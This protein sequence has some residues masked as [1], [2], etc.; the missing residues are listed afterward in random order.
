MFVNLFERMFDG[1][2]VDLGVQ[3]IYR[4]ENTRKTYNNLWIAF[5]I[6]YHPFNGSKFYLPPTV[7]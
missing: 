1:F 7:A 6:H 5:K 4:D 3:Q 2:Q